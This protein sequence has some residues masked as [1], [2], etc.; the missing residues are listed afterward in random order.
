MSYK[1]SLLQWIWQELQFNCSNLRTS[2]GKKIE[3]YE[4][5]FQNNG[6]GPDF[7][8]ARI[9]IDGLEWHGSVEIHKTAKEWF[10]HSHHLDSNFNNV[11]L[12]V[13][14]SEREM[15]SA[16]T[17]SGS[18]LFTLC[19]QPYLEKGLHDLL[20][21]SKKGAIPCS[22]NVKFIHQQALDKQVEIAHKEYFDYK[23]DEILEYY[24]T[25]VPIPQA[26]RQAFIHQIYSTFGISANRD[27]M[28]EL[29]IN[30]SA[31]N[32][33][34]Y[35]L[36]EWQREV[37]AKA[38]E[39]VHSRDKILWKST[40]LRPSGK[41]RV[42]V[43]QASA[44]HYAASRLQPEDYLRGPGRA[45]KSITERIP[46]SAMPGSMMYRLI[47]YTAF[48]PSLYLLGKLLFHTSLMNECYEC[49]EQQGSFVPA[50]IQDKFKKAGFT[51]NKSIRKL[52]LAHQY[53]RYC[54]QKNCRQCEVFKNAIRA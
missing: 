34:M 11:I 49:W 23:L 41:P 36:A 35:T 12:H 4:T 27:Q 43:K 47:Y 44:F 14:G 31:I 2:C 24:P 26:W 33:T 5:G 29:A 6:A 7:L 13:V 54:L 48:L 28:G 8:G 37:Q 32:C 50:V 53:K 30:V 39:A 40:G 10:R 17:E 51:V 46:S 21:Q 18:Q 45:W 22:G 25:G 15:C 9:Y 19:L 3:I 52:G 16:E 1:E 20:Y 38:F 42:R